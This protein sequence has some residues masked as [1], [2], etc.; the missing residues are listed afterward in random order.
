M[1][2]LPNTTLEACRSIQ[3]AH[4]RSGSTCVVRRYQGEVQDSHG[5]PIL[6]YVDE[7]PEW[8][9]YGYLTSE[10]ATSEDTTHTQ[11]VN[12]RLPL[13]SNID[14]RD[15]LVIDDTTYQVQGVPIPGITCDVVRAEAVTL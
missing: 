4:A 14:T 7:V 12:V 9:G 8:F 1:Y 2:C 11:V 15:L 13:G 3:A 10:S 5:T 6:E